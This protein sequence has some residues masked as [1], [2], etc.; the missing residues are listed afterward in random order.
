M[1]PLLGLS[2]FPYDPSDGDVV[3]RGSGLGVGLG[4]DGRWGGGGLYDIRL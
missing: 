4:V 3:V 1:L 2:G